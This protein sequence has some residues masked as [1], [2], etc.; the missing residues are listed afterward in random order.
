VMCAVTSTGMASDSTPGAHAT[1]TTEITAFDSPFG[2][3]KVP[4][5]VLR[6]VHWPLGLALPFRLQ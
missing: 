3:P 5:G 4:L 6:R 1:E 2:P